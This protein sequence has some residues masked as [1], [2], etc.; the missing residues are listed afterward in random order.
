MQEVSDHLSDVIYWHRSPHLIRCAARGEDCQFTTPLH[1]LK[2]QQ[3]MTA[4]VE[5]LTASVDF[6]CQAVGTLAN[7]LNL[8]VGH[9][10]RASHD[11]AAPLPIIATPPPSSAT[12]APRALPPPPP[13][14]QPEPKEAPRELPFWDTRAGAEQLLAQTYASFTPP[15]GSDHIGGSQDGNIY[16]QGELQHGQIDMPEA[17]SFFGLIDFGLGS[18]EL[19]SRSVEELAGDN[20]NAS[21][22]MAA[23]LLG[24]TNLEAVGSSDPRMDVVKHGLISVGDAE[25]LVDL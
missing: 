8:N 22:S 6:L 5:H 10:P 16:A 15:F 14:V 19:S 1:D 17:P 25:V 3:T 4:R 7:H 2:W 24:S 13:P 9:P 21:K 23:R 20:L 18:P 12:S 11:A